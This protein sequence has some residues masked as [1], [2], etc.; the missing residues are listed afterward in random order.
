MAKTR[1]TVL[2]FLCISLG[3]SLYANGSQ[4]SSNSFQVWHYESETGAMGKAWAEAMR[5]FEETHP[6]VTLDFEEKGFEQIRQTAGMVLNSKEAPT[7]LEY[8]KGNATAGLLSSQGLLTDLSSVAQER[9]WDDILGS[10]LALT[11]RYSDGVMGSGNLYGVTNYGEYVMV[12]YN[13]DMFKKQG[14][15]VPKTLAEFEAVMD[16]FAASGITPLATAG[17][18]YPAQQVFYEL[19]LS[20]ANTKW[21]R[22]Y[23]LYEG[24][25]NFKGKE[26]TYGANKMVEW[27]DKG[28]MSPD[29]VSMKA[30]DM[31]LAFEGGTNPIMI[32]GSWWFGRF[33]E[34]ITDFDWGVFIF[35]GNQFHPGSGGNLW[36]VPEGASNKELAYDFIDITLQQDV[37]TLL[38]NAGGIP[39]NADLTQIKDPKIKELIA[40]FNAIIDK[41][42]LAFYPDWPVPGYYDTLVAEVQNLMSQDKSVDEVLSSLSEA[43][44][45]R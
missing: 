2:M 45:N 37:Q 7:I 1:F 25:V 3:F 35:P 43:Y 11:S 38:G 44:Y 39:I 33:M 9:G 5:Q 18:E 15:K 40:G 16:K 28:Y 19:V 24:D 13:K 32:S 30:E 6:G 8:N 41:D 34:E 17:A 10:S 29:A 26:F 4:E 22:S 20:Q 27:M 36:I 23:Q 31:G 14:V 12:Y 21:L 42:G